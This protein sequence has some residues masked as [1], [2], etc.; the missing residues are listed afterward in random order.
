M[1]IKTIGILNTS[2]LTCEGEYILKKISHGG[3]RIWKI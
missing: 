1:K 2:I 3:L